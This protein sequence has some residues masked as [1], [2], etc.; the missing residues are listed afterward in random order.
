MPIG[1]RALARLQKYL[2]EARPSLVSE[3]DDG[4]M[5]SRMKRITVIPRSRRVDD[6]GSSGTVMSRLQP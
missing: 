5:E 2:D 1:D 6:A 3:P 4:F